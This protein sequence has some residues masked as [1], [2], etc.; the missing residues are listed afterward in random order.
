MSISNVVYELSENGEKLY[1]DNP[2]GDPCETGEDE[3]INT[4]L[5]TLSKI[6]KLYEEWGL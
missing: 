5:D 1:F 4:F 6:F 2:L 3:A